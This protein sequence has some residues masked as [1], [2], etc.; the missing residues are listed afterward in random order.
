MVELQEAASVLHSATPRSLVLLDELG[1]GTSTH[2]G[3][4]IAYAVLKYLTENIGCITLF[5]THYH[6]LAS[7]FAFT[8]LITLKHM[9]C[10]CSPGTSST[11]QS[12]E[13]LE[14]EF[15]FSPNKTFKEKNKP[16]NDD[17]LANVIF[18]YQ[19][20]DG[21]S[22][23]SYGLNVALMAGIPQSIV[24]LAKKVADKFAESCGLGQN[25]RYY[26]A[27]RIYHALKIN[28]FKAIEKE[29]ELFD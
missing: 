16:L 2:D 17:L 9:A 29:R 19:A 23:A 11:F 15:A 24:E 10:L 3:Y 5:S 14:D 25:V 4:A 27:Q 1:R 22:P 8:S 20:R 6:Q 18:L 13:Q 7:E 26:Q 12:D 21:I 28:N